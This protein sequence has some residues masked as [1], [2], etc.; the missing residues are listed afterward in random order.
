[1]D[2]IN[3][4]LDAYN[5]KWH[6]RSANIPRR[7]SVYD[8][9]NRGKIDLNSRTIEGPEYLSVR[10]DHNAT[11]LVF[12]VDRYYDRMDLADTCCIIQ[13]KTTDKKTGQSFVAVQPVEYYDIDTE[14]GKI[15]IPWSVPYAATQSAQTIEYNFR[16]FKIELAENENYELTYN[17]NTISTT[18]TILNSINAPYGDLENAYNVFDAMDGR[19]YS[20]EMLVDKVERAVNNSTLYWRNAADIHD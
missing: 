3:I 12:E 13:F 5:Y 15:L 2:D 19:D 18:S 10:E 7:V 4:L 11:Y 1:M 16:F 17:L 6:M 9:K 14:Q 20:Y 8:Q